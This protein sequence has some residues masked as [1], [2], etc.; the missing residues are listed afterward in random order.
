[1]RIPIPDRAGSAA[2]VFTLAAELG[3]NIAS[4]EVVHSRRGQPRCRRRAGRRGRSPTCSAAACWRGATGRPCSGCHERRRRDVGR[5]HPPGATARRRDRRGPVPAS[6]S[7][8]N[9]A[10]VC[11][12]LAEGTSELIGVP[13]ATTP[14][15]CSTASSSSAAGS[16]SVWT[17]TSGPPTSSARVATWPPGPMTLRRRTG[18]HHLA[19]RHR[20]GGARS[21]AVHDRRR[22]R[23]CV[24]G[25]WRRSTTRSPRSARAC[26]P[27]ETAGHLPVT[28][29]G[30]LRRADA[31]V[32]PRR[33]DE[34]V[35]HG[36][37]A[38]RPVLTGRSQAVVVVRSRLASVS[39]DDTFGDGGV[40]SRPASSSVTAS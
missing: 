15:R 40:R 35:P 20:A 12:A 30:P 6:K 22:A 14:R 28:V 11:A 25:R 32:M 23:R 19:V 26:V 33:R 10:L 36:A 21:G 9:R 2:E 5:W 29:Q 13:A 24:D 3:V 17:T 1:M 34:P 38:H 8:A 39:R 7:I 27:G 4:F 18:R 16:A 31:V 37:D